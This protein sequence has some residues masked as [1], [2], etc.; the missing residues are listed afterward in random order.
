MGRCL[1]VVVMVMVGHFALGQEP[2]APPTQ[3][4]PAML[5]ADDTK[6][7]RITVSWPTKSGTTAKVEGERAWRSPADKSLLGKNIECYAAMGGYRLEKGAGHPKGA[8][9]R[10]GLSKLDLR[11]LFFE[12]IAEGATVTIT[13]DHIAMN[14]PA[15]PR[16]KTSLMQLKYRMSDLDACS[17][18]GTNKSLLNTAD[19]KDPLGELIVPGTARLGALDG[20]PGHGSVE[21]K[22][23]ADG[24]VTVTFKCPYVLFR[25]IRD[26]YQRTA[27]GSF[28][29]PSIVNVEIE[30]VPKPVDEQERQ[31]EPVQHPTTEAQ[32]GQ[33]PKGGKP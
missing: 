15:M 8:T 18:D 5:M 19:P 14:Q 23:E 31:R 24:T 33:D 12:D 3:A 26:P 21:A 32:P 25:H 6:Q 2:P 13:V 16:P 11:K 28:F 22:V 9:V 17:L 1:T 20:Q 29:E 27:P 10:A 7:P 4:T 30:L